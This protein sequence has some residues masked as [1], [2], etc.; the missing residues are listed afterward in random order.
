MWT[1]T[2]SQISSLSIGSLGDLN[3]LKRLTSNREKVAFGSVRREA[4]HQPECSVNEIIS[5]LYGSCMKRS[6]PVQRDVDIKKGRVVLD[7]I[8]SKDISLQK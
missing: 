5:Y 6:P 8:Q 7:M 1:I 4:T 2:N 3:E